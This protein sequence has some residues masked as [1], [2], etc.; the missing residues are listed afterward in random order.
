MSDHPATASLLT[1]L[2]LRATPSS[3]TPNHAAG[4]IIGNWFLAHGILNPRAAIRRLG[5]DHNNAP[6]ENL[7]KYGEAAVQAGKITRGQLNR[8]KRREA[9]YENVIE[10]FPLF[11]AGVLLALH[12]GVPTEIINWIGLW[13]SVMRVAYATAA[14]AIESEPLNFVP[15]LLWWLGNVSCL[16]ALMLAGKRL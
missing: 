10:G 15:S 11:I 3:P 4:Y 12:A 7:L 9:A 1:T 14:V 5:Q 16:T 6:R 13:F 2:G 8:L